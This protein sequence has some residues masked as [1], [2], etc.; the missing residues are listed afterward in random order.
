MRSKPGSH[1]WRVLP[2]RRPAR[3]RIAGRTSVGAISRAVLALQAVEQHVGHQIHARPAFFQ[4]V[5]D[6]RHAQLAARHH[7]NSSKNARCARADDRPGEPLAHARQ[8]ARRQLA[9]ALGSADRTRRWRRR[10]RRGVALGEEQAGVADDVRNLAAAAGDDRRHHR[11]SPR[12]T[13]GRTARA[14]AA[15]SGSAHRARPSRRGAPAR[16]SCATPVTT[17]TRPAMR[18][19]EGIQ[20]GHASVRRRRTARATA[21][22]APRA[23]ASASRAPSPARSGRGTHDHGNRFVPS[24]PVRSTPR[25]PSGRTRTAPRPRPAE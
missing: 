2:G 23:R 21:G 4:V 14:S 20:I 16:S 9:P 25:E 22:A 7:N 11:P 24:E 15:S 12:S 6:H 13:S 3:R 5:G 1:G 19:G 8:A 10:P 18:G 17:C